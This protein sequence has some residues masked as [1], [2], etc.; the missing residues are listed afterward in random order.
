M[1]AAGLEYLLFVK[2]F[3]INQYSIVPSDMKRAWEKH[4]RLVTKFISSVMNNV[5]AY[6]TVRAIFIAVIKVVSFYSLKTGF[7]ERIFF[8]LC[9]LLRGAT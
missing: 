9:H 8:I 6:A 2:S 7:Q 1:V 5:Q 3:W 4:T